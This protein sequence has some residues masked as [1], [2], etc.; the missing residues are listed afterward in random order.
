MAGVYI[1]IPF[2]HS[3]C[4]YCDFYSLVNDQRQ[5]VYIEALFKEFG[6]R[7]QQ[8][9]W[10][11]QTSWN[12]LYLGGGTPSTL[13]SLNLERLCQ[14]IDFFLPNATF[15]ERTIEVNPEDIT[16][17]KV[18]HL[19]TL[20]F[21]R[22]SMGVQS[23]ND[24]E[25]LFLRRRHTAA[26]AIEAVDLLHSGGI[27]NISIDLIFALPGSSLAQ[28]EKNIDQALSLGCTH[29]SAYGLTYEKRTPL[30]DMLRTKKIL[31]VEDSLYVEQYNLLIDKLTR[32][33][34]EHYELSNFALSGY[35][36]LHNSSYWEET[37]YL[38]LGTSANGYDG[39]FRYANKR[40]LDKY[41]DD[42]QQGIL[43]IE[44]EEELSLLDKYN[45]SIML[46]LRKREG[47]DLILFES[48]F[49]KK[50]LNRLLSSS[51]IFCDNGSLSIQDNHLRLTRQGLTVADS[52]MSDLFQLE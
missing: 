2:C 20:G 3:K 23:F 11:H 49:G 42:L 39:N 4:I 43:P 30:F 6:L 45:E 24:N 25:L 31:S 5:D 35:T 44:F 41:L 33:G 38:G 10:K 40:S 48:R 19:V 21:N 47:V 37:P 26:K 50:G 9:V 12:T 22:V 51:Q 15:R 29:I 27:K 32:A 13:S 36:S 16:Q 1:H 18:A 17:D 46:A 28:W 7:L 34:Y 8:P 52:I 14:N